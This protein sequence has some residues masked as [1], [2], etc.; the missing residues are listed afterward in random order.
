MQNLVNQINE[1]KGSDISKII[2]SKLVDFENVPDLFSELC[3]CLMTAGFRADKSI[4][5]QKKIGN[6]FC[7]LGLDE[8]KKIL[9]E[10]GHRFWPQRAERI[11][12]AREHSG[13]LKELAL[14]DSISARIWVVE[15][16]YGMGMKEASHYLRNTGRKD[17]AIVDFHILDLLNREGMIEKP[18]TLGAKKYLEIESVLKGLGE[19]LGM[20]LAEL[21]LYL[22]YIETGKV[23]K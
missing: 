20:N 18:K 22:W 1:L 10:E 13:Y 12:R 21:D 15:N 11:V 17:V 8:L 6:G 23:L 16:I 14:M 9:K 2:N 4:E 5:I 7:D 3:F 19:K